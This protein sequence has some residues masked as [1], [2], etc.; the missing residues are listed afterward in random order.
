[1]STI[2]KKFVL[3]LALATLAYIAF[4]GLLSFA[5]I[6]TGNSAHAHFASLPADDEQLLAW[7]KRQRNVVPHTV[8]VNRIDNHT[9]ELVFIQVRNGWGIPA[10]PEYESACESFGYFDGKWNRGPIKRIK[11]ARPD[12]RRV[13]PI[14]PSGR[15]HDQ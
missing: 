10:L 11:K 3:F 14:Q 4:F 15:K 9:I 12:V 7:L 13:S 5:P 2:I 1:M 8:H 6:S